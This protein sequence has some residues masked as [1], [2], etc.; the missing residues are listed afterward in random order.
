MMIIT[1]LVAP[2]IPFMVP[3]MGM[4]MVMVTMVVAED[5]G[6]ESSFGG[7]SSREVP[8]SDNAAST[9]GLLAAATLLLVLGALGAYAILVMR[10]GDEAARLEREAEAEGSVGVAGGKRRGLRTGAARRRR[11]AAGGE[12]DDAGED[13]GGDDD[14]DDDAALDRKAQKKADRAEERRYADAARDAKSEKQDKYMERKRAKE[15]EREERE[16]AEEEARQKEEEERQRKEDEEAK[17]WMSMMSTE[18]SGESKRED[19]DDGEAL[20]TEFVAY[21]QRRKM[22]ELEE[23]ASEFGLRTSDAIAR[24]QALEEMGRLTG[25]MDDRGKF[26]YV[27]EEEF[28]AVAKHIVDKGRISIS[29]LAAASNSLIDLTPRDVESSSRAKASET[30]IASELLQLEEED[31]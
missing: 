18:E 16:R 1:L 31:D 28:K 19:E 5:A 24:V 22:V 25:I 7:E 3:L 20:L 26:I 4:G 14:D 10:R 12:G 17:K 21:I 29:Q 6:G 15:A 2:P 8:N 27:S 9:L 23:L 13:G 11:A 30:N